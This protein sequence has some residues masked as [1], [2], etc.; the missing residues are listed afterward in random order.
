MRLAI[1]SIDNYT[2]LND[3]LEC[4]AVHFTSEFQFN[5]SEYYGL[6]NG[7]DLAESCSFHGNSNYSIYVVINDDEF[8]TVEQV[9]E[10]ISSL[11]SVNDCDEQTLIEKL[12]E[13]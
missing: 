6:L 5:Y 12:K 3:A 1:Y 8:Y 4:Q 7:L 9:N 11:F 13:V 10:V 2:S